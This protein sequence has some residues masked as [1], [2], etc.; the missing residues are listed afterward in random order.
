MEQNEIKSIVSKVVENYNRSM[1]DKSFPIEASARHVHLTAEAAETLFGK[2]ASLVCKRDL[3]LPGFLAEQRVAIVTS[4]GVFHN[5]A[6][7]GP[8]R[9]AIQ[10][11][12]SKTDARALGISPPVNLSGDLSNAA[13][14]YLIGEKGMVFAP[15]SAIIAKAHVHMNMDEAKAYGVENGQLMQV[16]I[17]SDRPVTLSNVL[18]RVDKGM[19]ACMHIDLDEANA[20]GY[21]NGTRGVLRPCC[22]E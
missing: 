18:I 5:V 9:S 2:G 12:L 1:M 8:E 4:K 7:L 19:H 10:V 15:G 11:E 20:C 13:D 3:S 14:V 6:V 17:L 21:I 22:E 16:S